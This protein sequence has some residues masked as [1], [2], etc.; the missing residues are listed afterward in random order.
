MKTEGDV[1]SKV[2]ARNE[3]C[4]LAKRS[5]PPSNESDSEGDV[6]KRQKRDVAKDDSDTD[7]HE[8]NTNGNTGGVP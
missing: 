2:P 1:P 6:S 5:R 7:M 8:S 3:N 4:L